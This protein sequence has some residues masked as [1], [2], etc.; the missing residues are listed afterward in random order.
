MPAQT[1]KKIQAVRDIVSV[2]LQVRTHH[3]LKVR[4]PLRAAHVVLNDVSLKDSLASAAAISPRPAE[5][6]RTRSLG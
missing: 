1:P 5:R 4:Q 6:S 3:K 2:G